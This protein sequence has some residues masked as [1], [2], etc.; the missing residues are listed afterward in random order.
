M[1]LS[2]LERAEAAAALVSI[3]TPASQPTHAALAQQVVFQ[4]KEAKKRLSVGVKVGDTF[5]E[6][7][8][9]NY[10]QLTMQ[11][12]EEIRDDVALDFNNAANVDID[13]AT[14]SW[15]DEAM[16]RAYFV[17]GGSAE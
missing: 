14:M 9:H 7:H 13:F 4:S 12:I 5:A 10:S 16:V 8:R 6:Y 3:R 1:Q 2:A 11:Q 17:N 15:W